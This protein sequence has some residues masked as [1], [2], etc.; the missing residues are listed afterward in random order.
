M[1]RQIIMVRH[2][3]AYN[4]VEPD[5]Q[6]E[7]VDRS[8]PPLTPLGEK[9]AELTAAVVSA[10]GPDQVLSSPFI[11][12]AQ[13]A[14]ALL[15]SS[16]AKALLDA[17]LCEHF[18][19]GSLEHFAG[20]PS[21]RYPFYGVD[22]FPA[23]ETLADREVFP[24][25]P[26]SQDAVDRRV[27]SLLDEWIARDG[28]QTLALYSHGAVVGAVGRYLA[29]QMESD[30]NPKHCNVSRFVEA[31]DGWTLKEWLDTSHLTELMAS[32]AGQV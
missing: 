1:Q 27:G 13:T 24:H 26:E 10:F 15:K 12:A 9:Q 25:F 20:V 23:D 28:W 14:Q 2:G 7:V 32:V 21:E 8:N 3:E 16:D 6:R 19:F 31:A 18:A 17:R 11:R 29:P 22:R 4:T 30:P 5:G